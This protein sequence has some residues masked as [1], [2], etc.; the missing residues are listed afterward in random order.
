MGS[1]A[2]KAVAEDVLESLRRGKRPILGDI[3]FKR[4]YSKK[5]SLNPKNV[6]ET[7]T[8]KA[9]IAPF[10][11][12]LEIER[13]RAIDA[14]AGKIGK[15]KYRDLTDAVDKLTKSHQLLTG[16]ATANIAIGVKELKDDELVHIAEG[17]QS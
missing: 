8:Y 1:I 6:T 5:T 4:G 10:V 13:Q 17:G 16:G 9:T 12:K 14:M 3:V 2:A 11:E 7:K 15:A